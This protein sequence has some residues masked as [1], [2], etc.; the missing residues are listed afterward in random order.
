MVNNLRTATFDV[1]FAQAFGFNA[2]G[3][4]SPPYAYQEAWATV[5]APARGCSASQPALVRPLPQSWLSCADGV[6][7]T[8]VNTDG[9]RY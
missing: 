2:K 3:A 6:S 7:P 4:I 5:G 9:K 1:F 8:P